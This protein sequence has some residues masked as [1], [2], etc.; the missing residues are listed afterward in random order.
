MHGIQILLLLGKNP[1]GH[2]CTHP[3]KYIKLGHEVHIPL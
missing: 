1:I 3:N 2:V